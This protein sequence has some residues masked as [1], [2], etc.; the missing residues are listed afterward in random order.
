MFVLIV[1]YNPVMLILRWWR[2]ERLVKLLGG[3]P[4]LLGHDIPVVD[5]GILVVG[6][7]L[8]ED[9]LVV[10]LLLLESSPE[11]LS[12]GFDLRESF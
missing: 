7:D 6:G 8:V 1:F 11:A 10:F 3:L 2:P 9:G 5:G 12:R 4:V